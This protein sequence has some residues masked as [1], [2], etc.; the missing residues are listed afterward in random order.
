MI[1]IYFGNDYGQVEHSCFRDLEKVPS[2]IEIVRFDAFNNYVQDVVNECTSYSLFQQKKIVIFHHCYF[3]T[4]TKTKSLIT[5]SKQRY[6]TLIN[7]SKEKSDSD[8]ILLVPGQLDN[9]NKI[10]ASLKETEIIINEVKS[11]SKDE[12]INYGKE[13]AKKQNKEISDDALVILYDR[14]K[15]KINYKDEGDFLHFNNELNK[16]LEYKDNITKDDVNK[17]IIKPLDDDIFQTVTNLLSKNINLAISSYMQLRMLGY[18][19]LNLLPIFISQFTT[20]ARLRCLVELNKSDVQIMDELKMSN[21]RL[22]YS[23]NSCMFLS[24][25]TFINILNKLYEIE[26]GIKLYSDDPDTTLLQFLLTFN[27]NY[28]K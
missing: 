23:K 17:L 8:L 1:Y 20:Y 10:V 21:G 22:Y 12:Y 3:L 26:K 16:I 4:S 19:V 5:E 2:N 24:F 15:R 14:T 7:F 27:L 28:R 25:K 13:I 11:F 6:E 9:K 18:E